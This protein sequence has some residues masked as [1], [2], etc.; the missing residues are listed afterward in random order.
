MKLARND[1]CHCGSGKK[2]K[3]CHLA[4]D[5]AATRTALPSPIAEP[6]TGRQVAK[7]MAEHFLVSDGVDDETLAIA[8]RYFAE[9]DAGRGP[10]QQMM[11]FAEPLLDESDGST[12]ALNKALSLA[13]VFWNLAL[14]R[15]EDREEA[16]AKAMLKDADPEVSAAFQQMAQLMIARHETMF[17]EL[18][19]R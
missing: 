11:D 10:A 12:E 17:P 4:A 19:C 8:Q 14:A 5:E 13:T 7:R 9:K 18:H 1:P 6:L 15:E 16:I 3:R 2:Y